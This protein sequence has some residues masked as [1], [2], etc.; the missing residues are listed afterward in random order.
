MSLTCMDVGVILEFAKIANGWKTNEEL[1]SGVNNFAK[2]D[3][4][5]STKTTTKDLIKK[6]EDWY[7][8]HFTPCLE[9]TCNATSSPINKQEIQQM[10]R[11]FIKSMIY[12]NLPPWQAYVLRNWQV[13]AVVFVVVLLCLGGFVG[14]MLG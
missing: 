10:P 12:A 5:D 9:T 14:F 2:Q 6:L 8:D 7:K 1:C 13:V 3:L 11:S 4:N